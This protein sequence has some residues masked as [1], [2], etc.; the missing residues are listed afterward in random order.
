MRRLLRVLFS[1]A[2]RIF[3]RRIEVE[4]V[5]RVPPVG[6]VIF[7]ANHPN[8]LVD[9]LLLLCFAPRPVSFLA[10]APLF[11]M[12]LIGPFVRAFDSIP[13]HRQQDAGTDLSKNRETFET[14]RRLLARGGTLALFPE[15]ASHDAPKLLPMKTGAARIALGAAAAGDP[16]RIVPASL[17]Y[18]WKQR[19]RSDALVVFGESL[20][21]E[22]VPLDESG[23]PPGAAVHAL[24]DSIGAALGALTLQAETAETLA[25]VQTA[26]RIFASGPEPLA[27]ELALRRRFA[28]GHR[29]LSVGN[30][31]RLAA[32][33]RQIER[34]EAGRVAA[35]L[36]LE[37]LEP[38]ELG[39]RGVARLAGQNAGALL[40][41][42]LALAGALIHYPAYRLAGIIAKRI[43]PPGEDVLATA[44]VCLSML[45]FPATWLACAAVAWHF[46]GWATAAAALV[47]VPL[48]G[49]S[50]LATGEALQ[51]VAGRAWALFHLVFRR[52]AMRRLLAR[53]AA[54][55]RQILELAELV[56]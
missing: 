6:P 42:P 29:S 15:G 45:L 28:D 38:G 26:E 17:Y 37:D 14:A 50:A 27:D 54:I 43:V 9:P 12:P 8:S 21:V 52:P 13:V 35:G 24:T 33:S 22:P 18:T 25:L 34:F 49:W 55:R 23:N 44:K 1:R 36:S 53:R 2:L 19:F 47:V 11:R 48:A 31:H 51:T 20:A 16:P 39:A 7:V 30:P 56:P 46:A 4:G 32:I 5:S 40:F 10:K 3:F 41:L